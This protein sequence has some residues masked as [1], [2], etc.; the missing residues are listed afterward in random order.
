MWWGVG[1]LELWE[2]HVC[3]NVEYGMGAGLDCTEGRMQWRR[4]RR[5]KCTVVQ[6]LGWPPEKHA[7]SSTHTHTRTVHTH[8]HTLIRFPCEPHMLNRP[9][10]SPVPRFWT[11]GCWPG[12]CWCARSCA[13]C[14]RRA[15]SRTR[16]AARRSR[17]AATCR[18]GKGEG[19]G[20]GRLGQAGGGGFDGR[21]GWDGVAWGGGTP[22]SWSTMLWCQWC[23]LGG[24]K[25]WRWEGQLGT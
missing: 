6:W 25:W 13:C 21:G 2:G 16:A 10:P 7:P 18:S 3:G 19:G 24:L 22:V 5:G 23:R 8:K 15:A 12:W 9:V 14:G 4:G 11:G 20:G 1:A 17:C